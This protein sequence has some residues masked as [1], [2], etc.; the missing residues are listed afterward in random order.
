MSTVFSLIPKNREHL[1]HLV[2]DEPILKEPLNDGYDH[3][4]YE[5]DKC[6]IARRS[7]NYITILC[8]DIIFDYLPNDTK[9]W[10]TNNTQQGI[11]TIGDIRK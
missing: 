1:Y 4:S 3:I 5:N 10:A 11:Y 9:V 2:D 7:S 8:D 6:D